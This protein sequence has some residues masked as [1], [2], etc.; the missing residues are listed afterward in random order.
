MRKLMYVAPPAP[1]DSLGRSWSG[2]ARQAARRCGARGT[3]APPS[4][5]RRGPPRRP[6]ARPLRAWSARTRRS[7]GHVAASATRAARRR[8]AW[9]TNGRPGQAARARCSRNSGWPTPG[10]RL[11]A[12]HPSR[13]DCRTER[14]PL[15][16]RERA[17]LG[18]PEQMTALDDVHYRSMPVE[19][20]SP[21]CSLLVLRGRILR[22]VRDFR[23]LRLGRL[24][25]AAIP[26]K[27]QRLLAGASECC[28]GAYAAS[29]VPGVMTPPS[30]QHTRRHSP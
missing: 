4:P 1:R 26:G 19:R 7:A 27:S 13:D 16:P 10:A 20:A 21:T 5:R 12:C 18:R 6:A 30:S 24:L 11:L 23:S 14:R 2:R 29:A 17:R 15:H 22:P 25:G 9:A 3:G 28:T 8:R